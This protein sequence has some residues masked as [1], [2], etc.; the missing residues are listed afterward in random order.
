M[1]R[2]SSTVGR[3]SEESI[4]LLRLVHSKSP[5]C[6]IGRDHRP[7]RSR[8]P[9]LEC[10]APTLFSALQ[11]FA[12]TGAVGFGAEAAGV[13][14]DDHGAAAPGVPGVRR[15]DQFAAPRA[16]ADRNQ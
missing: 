6:R 11:D 4:F 5:P 10:A 14:A 13:A 9:Q 2:P 8:D 3:L 15:V 7:F 1:A 12:L 16:A